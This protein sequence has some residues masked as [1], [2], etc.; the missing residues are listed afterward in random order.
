MESIER[1][2][3][4]NDYKEMMETESHHKHKIIKDNHGTIRWQEDPFVR[5]FTDGCNLNDIVSGFHDKGNG[6]NSEIYREFYRKIGYS[7]SG[8]WEIFYWEM[9][10][11]DSDNYKQPKT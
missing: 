1:S 5:R 8:Y 9:N 10:N 7:L 3:L 6:K 2:D 4:P 11:P